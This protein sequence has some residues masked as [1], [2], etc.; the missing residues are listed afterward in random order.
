VK[1]YRDDFQVTQGGDIGICLV[2]SA[3][4]TT[5]ALASRN[6]TDRW[7]ENCD[8]FEPLGDDPLGPIACQARRDTYLGMVGLCATFGVLGYQN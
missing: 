5:L 4:P 7:S 2:S 3:I 6:A 8:W 1:A